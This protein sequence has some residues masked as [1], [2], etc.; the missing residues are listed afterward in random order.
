MTNDPN[1]MKEL[2]K[3]LVIIRWIARISGTLMLMF[4]LFFLLAHIFG[5]QDHK[6]G[7]F[8]DTRELITFIFFPLSYIAGLSVALKWEGTGSLI[9]LI[10]MTGLFVLR[11][12]LLTNPYILMPALPT[13]LYAIY[14]YA[15]NKEKIR[16][17][18]DTGFTQ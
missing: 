16:A 1:T 10:G 17:T 13:I 4:F 3:P 15:R 2:T 11:P 12:D 5:D 8:S 14:W 9:S 18:H 6:G 7:G